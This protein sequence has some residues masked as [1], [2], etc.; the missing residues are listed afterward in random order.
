MQ[1]K[2]SKG[3]TVAEQNVAVTKEGSIISVSTMYDRGRVVSQTIGVRDD[4]GNVRSETI[5]NGK[6]LP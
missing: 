6:L 3:E 1:T 4:S 5:L 2:N